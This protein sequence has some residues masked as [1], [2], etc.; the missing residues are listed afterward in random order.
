MFSKRPSTERGSGGLRLRF[1]IRQSRIGKLCNV[2][3]GRA[4]IAGVAEF[5]VIRQTISVS[6]IFT[7]LY[8]LL[9]ADNILR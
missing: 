3:R 1:T 8:N 9:Q 7:A 2:N 5:D 6:A 4:G